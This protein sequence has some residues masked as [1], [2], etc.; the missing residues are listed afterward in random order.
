MKKRLTWRKRLA[1]DRGVNYFDPQTVLYLRGD[2]NYSH[3]HLTNGQ[4]ILA[5]RTLKWFE[6][7]WP[8]FMRPHKQALVNPAYIHQ[9]TLGSTLRATSYL[10]MQDEARLAISRRRVPIV[11]E[12]LNQI[13]ITP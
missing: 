6:D 3:V 13:D 10:I 8:H 5:C 11:V 4:V 2:I 12:Q 7:Q 9:L 1:G